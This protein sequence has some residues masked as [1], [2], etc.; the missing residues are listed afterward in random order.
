MICE[1]TSA[2]E[3]ECIDRSPVS[4]R[5]VPSP[6]LVDPA[7]NVTGVSIEDDWTTIIFMRDL[8]SLDDEDYN[9]AE[10]RDVL[11]VSLLL[12]LAETEKFC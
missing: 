5:S 1:V 4:T 8:T 6:D 7:L 12:A 3:G 2:T 10:V 9:L 11:S